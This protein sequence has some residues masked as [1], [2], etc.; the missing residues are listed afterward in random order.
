[1]DNLVFYYYLLI[2]LLF[3][4]HIIFYRFLII[5]SHILSWKSG[6]SLSWFFILTC[7]STLYWW[8]NVTFKNLI[9]VHMFWCCIFS[10][11]LQVLSLSLSLSLSFGLIFFELILDYFGS[12]NLSLFLNTI[13]AMLITDRHSAHFSLF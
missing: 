12:K 9:W 1:M 4:S 3:S 6:Y 10:S 13:L 2:Y 5:L 11:P 8:I 7:N